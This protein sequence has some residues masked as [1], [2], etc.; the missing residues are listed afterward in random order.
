MLEQA[1]HAVAEQVPDLL[2]VETPIYRWP[3]ER[4]SL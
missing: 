1:V 4:P 2:G 3:P